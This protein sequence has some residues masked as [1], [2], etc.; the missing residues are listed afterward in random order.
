M[1]TPMDAHPTTTYRHLMPFEAGFL[2]T[3]TAI[4]TAVTVLT[5]VDW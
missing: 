5:A 3:V 1:V 4:Y 2:P